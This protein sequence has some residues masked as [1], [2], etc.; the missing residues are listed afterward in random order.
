MNRRQIFHRSAAIAGGLLV[1]FLGLLLAI[2]WS[3][4]R[5]GTID[6]ARLT[7]AL[8]RYAQ[9]RRTLGEV[10]GPSVTME[11]LVQK[12]YLTP[13]DVK[14][15]QG[16]TVSFFAETGDADPQG[17]LVEAR[18]PD[19]MV[20]AVLGDGSVQQF[21]PRRW[22]EHRGRI[23]QPVSGANGHPPSP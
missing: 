14:P 21:T 20:V 23:G 10:P 18:M 5:S 1:L 9:D 22:E 4:R 8:A 2:E 6:G 16:A 3:S 15:F 11:S 19:G 17:V 7:A 12:G 13:Q